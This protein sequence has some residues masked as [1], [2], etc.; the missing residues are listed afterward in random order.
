MILLGWEALGGLISRKSNSSCV[1]ST[2]KG[3]IL[4][5]Q[6]EGTAIGWTTMMTTLSEDFDGGRLYMMAP[7]GGKDAL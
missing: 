5:S 6:M 1:W 3:N 2:A 7:F 4:T